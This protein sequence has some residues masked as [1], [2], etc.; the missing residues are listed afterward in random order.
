MFCKPSLSEVDDKHEIQ[1]Y[2]EGKWEMVSKWGFNPMTIYKCWVVCFMSSGK[3]HFIHTGSASLHIPVE[4]GVGPI[5]NF[6][7]IPQV[8]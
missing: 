1:I 7:L 5:I 2:F 4:A 6:F 8:H 3:S